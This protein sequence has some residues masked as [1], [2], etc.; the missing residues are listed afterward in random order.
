MAKDMI[1][2]TRSIEYGSVAP[3]KQLDMANIIFAIGW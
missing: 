3:V 2:K 1:W